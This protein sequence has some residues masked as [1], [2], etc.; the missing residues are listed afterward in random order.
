MTI[1]ISIHADRDEKHTAC[2]WPHDYSPIRSRTVRYHICRAAAV[3]FAYRKNGPR[4]RSTISEVWMSL[5]GLKTNT[6]HE[7]HPVTPKKR[8]ILP[9]RKCNKKK[10]KI[11]F[12]PRVHGTRSV[13][14]ICGVCV[15][16]VVKVLK[17]IVS[18][19]IRLRSSKF[20]FFTRFPNRFSGFSNW[21]WRSN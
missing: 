10:N 17:A 18:N 21:R 16:G 12:A 7:K 1:K 19:R 20:F 11:H 14:Q 2:Q 15:S 5:P 3:P 9:S 6:L 4:T 8:E 13:W